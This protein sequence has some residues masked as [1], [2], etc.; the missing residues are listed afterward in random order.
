VLLV[1]LGIVRSATGRNAAPR[2]RSRCRPGW[3]RGNAA[4]PLVLGRRAVEPGAVEFRRVVATG[5]FV[6]GWP[7]YLDNRP[8][9]GRAASIC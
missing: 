9:K 2:K 1:A 6:R 5:E 4:A 8:Y 3:R 7:L